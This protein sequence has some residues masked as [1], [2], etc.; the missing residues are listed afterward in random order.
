MGASEIC[1]SV[2]WESNRD[3][4]RACNIN[5]RKCYFSSSVAP[6]CWSIRCSS[7]SRWSNSNLHV[8]ERLRLKSSLDTESY[9]FAPLQDDLALLLCFM[10]SFI[11][12]RYIREHTVIME[13]LLLTIAWWYYVDRSLKERWWTPYIYTTRSSKR[14]YLQY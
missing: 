1:S 3:T 6:T 14:K 13:M 8:F 12:S 4:R 11:M 2:R 10:I 9:K 5:I 7:L